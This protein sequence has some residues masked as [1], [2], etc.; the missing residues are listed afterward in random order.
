MFVCACAFLVSLSSVT[1]ARGDE[2]S[3]EPPQSFASF[4]YFIDQ[5][6][7]PAKKIGQ[8]WATPLSVY[9]GPFFTNDELHV[10]LPPHYFDEA[11]SPFFRGSVST[12][13][14]SIV[15]YNGYGPM[16][17]AGHVNDRFFKMIFKS[18]VNTGVGKIA[19]PLKPD[20]KV[21]EAA[22]GESASM[23][24]R[25]TGVFLPHTTENRLTGGIVVNGALGALTFSAPFNENFKMT[26]EQG[27][28]IA[29]V[30]IDSD[31]NRTFFYSLGEKPIAYEGTPNGAIYV[32][33]PIG[34]AAG[35]GLGGKVKGRWTVATPLDAFISDSLV[36]SHT[37]AG[38][39]PQGNDCLA[40]IARSAF[41]TR[42]APDLLYLYATIFAARQEGKEKIG[43]LFVLPNKDMPHDGEL[44]WWGNY[45]GEF[46]AIMGTFDRSTGQSKDGYNLHK[47]YDARLVKD[48]PPFFPVIG[49]LLEGPSQP[50]S[51]NK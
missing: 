32:N 46:P 43:T 7:F 2:N 47:F 4:A 30:E 23:K 1:P 45:I 24:F 15:Y 37:P 50:M 31:H 49:E 18:Q 36:Y 28:K 34:A 25:G 22:F 3:A 38:S 16:D 33:G 27:R 8:V 13:A 51:K 29:I 19:L 11:H 5:L 14:S 10:Y 6:Q 9:E 42:N 35:T 40:V 44:L 26:F 12:A 17:V 48:P 41:I 21:R 20:E 39:Q